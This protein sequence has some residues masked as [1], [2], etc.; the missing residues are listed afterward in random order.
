MSRKNHKMVDGKLL[1]TDKKYSN[2][3]MKQKEKINLWIGQE[4]RS[5]YKENGR[6]PRKEHEFQIVFDK[7]YDRIENAGIWIPY[8]E[9]HKR[10][11]GSRMGRIDKIA[12][13]IQKEERSL[14]I[15]QVQIESLEIELSVCKVTDY[16]K[17]DM[18]AE[19]CFTGKTDVENSLVCPSSVVPENVIK[20][21]DGWRVM[22]IC[23]MLDFSIIGILSGITTELA[24]QGIGIFAIST[25]NTDY[26]LVKEKDFA[27]ALESLSKKGYQCNKI[28]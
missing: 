14:A 18:N 1:Q 9:I 6:M 15:S 22:R 23:G 10:F 19:F 4:I 28:S 2:L 17:V 5:Y 21:D 16:S 13:R 11:M 27:K 7:L 12:G 8:G 24:R 3:K 20:R 25:F 26:I